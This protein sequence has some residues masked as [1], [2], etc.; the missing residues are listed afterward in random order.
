MTAERRNDAAKGPIGAPSRVSEVPVTPLA[1]KAFADLLPPDRRERA[2]AQL[3][4]LR[5]VLGRRAIVSVNSTA[6][7]GGVAEMLPRLIGYERGAGLDARWFVIGAEAPFFA[8]TKQLHHLLHGMDGGRSDLDNGRVLYEEVAR[9]AAAEFSR[10]VRSGDIVVLHDPQTAG[11]AP[12]L[13][14]ADINVIWQCHIGADATNE[15]TE[16]AWAFLGPYLAAVEAFVFSRRSYVPPSLDGTRAHMIPPT[17]DPFSCKNRHLTAEA[18]RTILRAVGL[19][20]GDTAGPAYTLRR[21]DGTV[22]AV[23][24]PVQVL[25]SGPSPSVE[26][27]L[28][29]QVSRWDPL[30]DMTG[31]IDVFAELATH[32]AEPQLMLVGPESS[33]VGDDPEG[34]AVFRACADRWASLPRTIR[35]RVH[36]VSLPMDDPECNAIIVNAMQRHATVVMQKSLAEGFGLTVTEAMWKAAP[37]VASAVGGI[38]DQIEHGRDGILV[39]EP[40]DID[41]FARALAHLLQSP[42]EAKRLGQAA[43]RRVFDR[44]LDDRQ[45]VE[46]A[47][48]YETIASRSTTG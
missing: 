43:H 11:L 10:F 27:P 38:V 41:G 47:E 46:R 7:G 30:K 28:V 8:L 20:D 34:E 23:D 25:R 40:R 36:L 32:I 16:H 2:E 48:L 17:I 21:N 14:A 19:L 1:L 5:L 37:V 18:S 3:E 45:L 15:R 9:R 12:H 31:A 13:R 6:T 39:D 33:G 26:T 42:G 4:H 44:S 22:G 35:D 29:V 24:R